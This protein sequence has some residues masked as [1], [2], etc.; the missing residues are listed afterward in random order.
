MTK[1]DAIVIGAGQAG[2]PLSQRLADQGWSVALIEQGQLGGTC[3]NTGCTPTKTMIASAQVA[4]YARQAGRWGVEAAEV[5][6][7][8]P[9]IVARKDQIVAQWRAGLVKKVEDRKNLHLYRGH[10]RF[11]APNR[12]RVGGD[13]NGEELASDRMFI[14]AGGRPNIP[15]VIAGEPGGLNRVNYLTNASILDLTELPEHL[16]ILGGGYIGLEFGQMFRRFGSQVTIVDRNEQILPRE[17][18]DVADE[19]RKSLQ[20]EG[21]RFV[22]GAQTDRVAAEGGRIALSVRVGPGAPG[23][24]EGSHLLVATGRRP[25]SDDL[26][27]DAAGVETD[28]QGFIRVNGRLET[29]VPGIWAL[30]DINGGP[31]FTHISYNDFQIVY[32]NLIEG[33]SL[34]T[35]NRQ[36][37]YCAFTD[38]QLGRVGM[39][40][41]EARA[42]GRPLKIGKIPMNWVARAIER[43]E[44][45]GL[46]KVIVD[47][48]TDRILGAA[49]LGIE[50]GELVQI[51]GAVMLAGAPYTLLKG[52][53]YIHP[54]LAEGF[55]TL[56]EQ[57][58]IS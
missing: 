38:P 26:G 48:G 23:S 17:D 28:G 10:A 18:T 15:H 41:K 37:P 3:V 30:G 16:L 22:L 20:S 6:A 55:W 40:E 47:A 56:M 25:N 27:L 49:I 57:V 5:R 51:L 19:L 13:E 32:A 9:R 52:A 58:K 12:V 34:S 11:V 29:N 4:H 1:F 46:M 33:A 8:L 43:D 36:V 50:G 31:A 14:D 54:T 24:L 21:I 45:A 7:D 44:T 35:A 39:T 2:N 42:T 53:V